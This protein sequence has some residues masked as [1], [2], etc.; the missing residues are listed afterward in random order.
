MKNIFILLTLISFNAF[1]QQPIKVEIVESRGKGADPVLVESFE[2]LYESR[3]AN[4][5]EAVSNGINKN[6]NT[7]ALPYSKDFY[8]KAAEMKAEGEGLKYLEEG[9]YSI[10][11]TASTDIGSYKKQEKIA[12]KEVEAFANQEG[13][14]Y[15]ILSIDRQKLAL[16]AGVARCLVT[17]KVSNMDGSLYQTQE[18]K[19]MMIV[20]ENKEKDLL[21]IKENK[22]KEDATKKILSLKNLLKEGIISEEEYNKAAEPLKRIILDN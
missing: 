2:K 15:E 13:I 22:E 16:G 8:M 4:Y 9:I 17:F 5:G 1:G 7:S 11:Q 19:D 6:S 21:I 20:N 14:L 3:G 10:Q 12:L 18:E